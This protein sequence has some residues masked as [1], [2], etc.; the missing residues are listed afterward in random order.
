MLGIFWH[1]LGNH[2]YILVVATIACQDFCENIKQ[3][4]SAILPESCLDNVVRGK[5]EVKNA[6]KTVQKQ[7][8]LPKP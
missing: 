1:I 7:M 4:F 8:R 5:N 2:G 6:Q 3:A